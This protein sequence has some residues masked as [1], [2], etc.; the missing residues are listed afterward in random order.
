MPVK[1]FKHKQVHWEAT[2][3]AGRGRSVG[4]RKWGLGGGKGGGGGGDA[5]VC[6]AIEQLCICIWV[7]RDYTEG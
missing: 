4:R 6:T 7:K 1:M 5:N 3:S 2:R